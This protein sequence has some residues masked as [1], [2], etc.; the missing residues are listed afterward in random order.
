MT[1]QMNSTRKCIECG[2]PVPR[3]VKRC[4]L[5]HKSFLSTRPTYERTPEH[6]KRM[7]L[8][9]K[10]KPKAYPSA[11]ER[12]EVAEKI[13][14][15]WTAEMREAARC[16][17][18]RNAAN[19]EWRL[20][21]AMS[22]AEELNPRWEG[23]RSV[24]PYSPGFG[25]KVRQLVRCRDGFACRQCGSTNHLCVHHKD[26]QKNNHDIENLELLC[27]KCHTRSHVKHRSELKT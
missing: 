7:S 14:R 9:T 22:L 11:S 27:R 12:P 17:G 20:K 13:R 23:G 10:G 1:R 2:V 6:R 24:S 5:C 18:L 15:A 25:S 19:P 26:F 8:A 21:I 4:P 16:R 3:K